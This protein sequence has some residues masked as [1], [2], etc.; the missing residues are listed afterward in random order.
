MQNTKL[1]IHLRL[2]NR[3]HKNT[4][5]TNDENGEELNYKQKKQSAKTLQNKARSGGKSNN[6]LENLKTKNNIK[7]A[8]KSS[9]KKHLEAHL[10]SETQPI[11]SEVNKLVNDATNSIIEKI[12]LDEIENKRRKL[13]DT[14]DENLI[15]EGHD[16]TTNGNTQSKYIYDIID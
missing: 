11:N 10:N 13:D 15:Q 12:C 5:I 6:V 4:P 8:E 1:Q 16:A 7:E 9:F 3:K 2:T 14:T